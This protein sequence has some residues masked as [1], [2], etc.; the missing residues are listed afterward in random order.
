MSDEHL[1]AVE[2]G[3]EHETIHFIRVASVFFVIT[4]VLTP[5]FELEW[6]HKNS[7][8]I[9]GCVHVSCEDTRGVLLLEDGVVVNGIIV[10][11]ASRVIDCTRVAV[12][13]A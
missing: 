6:V 2:E 8:V 10:V 1:H 3:R 13:L 11:A 9:E 5:K 12:I 4:L 7:N